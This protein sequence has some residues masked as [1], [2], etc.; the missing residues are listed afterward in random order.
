MITKSEI[1]VI[2]KS[3]ATKYVQKIM[4]EVMWSWEDIYQTLQVGIILASETVDW[5]HPNPNAYIRFK[6]EN[7]L[8]DQL[9]EHDPLTRGERKLAQKNPDYI[10]DKWLTPKSLPEKMIEDEASDSYVGLEV[11]EIKRLIAPLHNSYKKILVLRYVMEM[12]IE[13]T[14]KIVGIKRE[15][16]TSMTSQAIARLREIHGE[17]LGL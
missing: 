16:V 4:D 15:S 11:D 10:P 7:Y 5:S 9:R 12:S 14:A 17:E 8:R 6:A 1:E 13:E 2:A 3:L